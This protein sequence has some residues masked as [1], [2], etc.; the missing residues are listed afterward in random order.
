[1][2]ILSVKINNILSIE[3]AELH[4]EESGLVLVEGWNHDLGRANGAGKT[5]I[6]N[7]ISFALYDKVPRKI[8]ASQILR[9]GCSKGYAECTIEIGNDAWVVKRSRPKGVVFARNGVVV[10][11]TQE[12]WE[13]KMRLSYAQ[14]LVSVYC[15]QRGDN[16][17]LE[18]NDADKK[19]FL[20][21]LLD[22]DQF[23]ELKKASDDSAKHISNDV[24]DILN[25]ANAARSKIE[26]Y[27]ESLVNVDVINVD[28]KVLQQ[29]VSAF[30]SKIK[31]LQDVKKPD[32]SNYIKLENQLASKERDFSSAR[33]AKTLL[34]SQYRK[35]MASQ[36][37]FSGSDSCR[38]C[39]STLDLTDAKAHHAE[40]QKAI[41]YQLS[42]LKEQIDAYDA[43]L[44]KE[45]EVATLQ[46]KLFDKKK[47][48]SA[49][50]DSAQEFA[51]ELRLAVS[52]KSNLIE[53]CVLKLTNNSD[54]LSK[55]NSLTI[56]LSKLDELYSKKVKDL[57]FYKILS[58]I[59]SPTGAQAYIL[60]SIIDSFN[61][62]VVNYINLVWPTASYTLN[63]YKE[64]AK[65]DVTAKF[66]ECLMIDEV[67]VSVGS[68]SGGELRA[69]SL[70][71]DFA[72][73]DVMQNNFGIKINPTILDEPFDGLDVI[74][75]E[76]VISLLEKIARDRQIFVVDHSSETK[77]MFSK[78]ITVELKNKISTVKVDF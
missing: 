44:S 17:F 40:E 52:K 35:L 21:Q 75:K 24:S 70:C 41:T 43:T 68:L 47:K 39:G 56:V 32:I 77:A 45:N 11:L 16:R 74:G 7:A 3:Q 73:M 8:T 13:K 38:T 53:N 19:N 30:N 48:E 55:V 18:L 4:F 34:H 61:E 5:A 46:Q 51:A 23:H 72:I 64:T 31:L 62:V 28:I 66:S 36:T 15:A 27:T 59:Y 42:E 58:A 12:E 37:S 26:A 20:L 25:K 50:Y 2:K 29:E 67:E 65:G 33:A 10:N 57:E 22:L 71:V 78:V 9:R 69:I 49:E 60:D 1:M 14:F 63:S 54:L 76:I 6:F